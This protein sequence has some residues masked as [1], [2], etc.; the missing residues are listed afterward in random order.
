[1]TKL[2]KDT[3]IKGEK[4]FKKVPNLN[5]MDEFAKYFRESS[6]NN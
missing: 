6:W 1:M 3:T 5:N 2:I 4:P